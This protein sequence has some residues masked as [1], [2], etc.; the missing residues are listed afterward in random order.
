MSYDITYGI[1][2]NDTNEPL[3][4]TEKNSQAQK[5]NYDYQMG[6]R[7]VEGHVLIKSLGLT[8]TDNYK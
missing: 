7:M 8:D 5:T 4:K 1:Q 6:K 2:K 3:Y